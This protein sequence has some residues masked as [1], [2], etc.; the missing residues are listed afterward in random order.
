MMIF[1]GIPYFSFPSQIKRFAQKIAE[2]PDGAL[3]VAGFFLM[4]FGLL[5]VYIGTSILERE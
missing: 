4:L 1:E 2:I 3:R 5:V